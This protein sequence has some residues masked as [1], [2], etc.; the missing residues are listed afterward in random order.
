MLI[1]GR[2]IL[3]INLTTHILNYDKR[4]VNRE[5]SA[6]KYKRRK[7]ELEHQNDVSKRQQF[8]ENENTNK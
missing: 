5:L 2:F 6:S 4:I 8:L 3:L 1:L 7:A